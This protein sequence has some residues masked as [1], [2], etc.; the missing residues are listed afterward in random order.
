VE[1][2]NSKA[3]IAHEG[4]TTQEYMDMTGL[5][6]RVARKHIKNMISAGE[7]KMVGIR[8]TYS[9]GGAATGRAPQF[10]SV[11]ES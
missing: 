7:V 5:S 4:W 3:D 11:D 2:N 6:E 10:L 9:I 1:R 8:K